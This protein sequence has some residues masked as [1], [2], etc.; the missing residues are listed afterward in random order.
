MT[1]RRETEQHMRWGRA[2]LAV[3]AAGAFWAVW[4]MVQFL[5]YVRFND[6]DRVD[7]AS[8]QVIWTAVPQLLGAFLIVLVAVL[9]YGRSRIASLAGAAVVL[10][11]P[12][13]QSVVITVLSATGGSPAGVTVGQ[14]LGGLIGAGVGYWLLRPKGRGASSYGY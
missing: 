7:D 12:V 9:V 4:S 3:L 13:G 14:F 1:M 6:V 11:F 5:A 2:V 10:A 8:N